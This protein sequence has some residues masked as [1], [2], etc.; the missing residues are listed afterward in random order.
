MGKYYM[1]DTIQSASHGAS[2]FLPEHYCSGLQLEPF[3][4]G[5]IWGCQN[6]GYVCGGRGAWYIRNTM[7]GTVHLVAPKSDPIQ[8]GMC[9]IV[10]TRPIIIFT[11]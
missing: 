10:K 9:T 1:G 11:L 4:P 7:P 6:M 2:L 5:D 8:H 3:S